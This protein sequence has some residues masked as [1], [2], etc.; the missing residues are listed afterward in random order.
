MHTLYYF[1]ICLFFFAIEEYFTFVSSSLSIRFNV[2]FIFSF[3]SL[4]PSIFPIIFAQFLLHVLSAL[5]LL[6]L[7]CRP[8]SVLQ[9][10]SLGSYSANTNYLFFPKPFSVVSSFR[11]PASSIPF[12]LSRVSNENKNKEN[13]KHPSRHVFF[14]DWTRISFFLSVFP[15]LN[16][17]IG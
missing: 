12:I 2:S 11:F 7:F 1:F 6:P 3:S 10:I 8:F 16:A 5:S 9:P 13:S 14:F 4:P 17:S 15:G